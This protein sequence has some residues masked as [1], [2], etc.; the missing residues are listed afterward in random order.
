[1]EQYV[2]QKLL[3]NYIIKKKFFMIPSFNLC[4]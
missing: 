1:V 2:K 3:K 4:R